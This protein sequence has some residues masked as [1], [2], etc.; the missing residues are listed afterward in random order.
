MV[1]RQTKEKIYK[2]P[3]LRHNV[4]LI[5]EMKCNRS[6]KIKKEIPLLCPS[7]YVWLF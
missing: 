5:R 7:F 3:S 2:T 1:A 6:L 4:E